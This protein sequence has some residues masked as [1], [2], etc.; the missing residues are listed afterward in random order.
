VIVWA[1]VAL[2]PVTSPLMSVDTDRASTLDHV[3]ALLREPGGPHRVAWLD[4]LGSRAGRGVVTRAE[5]LDHRPASGIPPG[6]VRR[7][8]AGRSGATVPARA[9]VPARWPAGVLRP[10]TVRAFNELRYR[11]APRRRRGH[12]EPLGG[13]MFPLD[14]LEAWPRLYGPLGLLQY[15]LVVPGGQERVLEA[16]IERL[17]RERVPCYLAVLKD[18]GPA[19]DAPLSFPIGGWTLALDLPRAAPGVDRVLSQLDELVAAAGGRVYLTKDAR[20][21]PD[22]VRAMYPRLEEWRA[23]RDRADPDRLWRSD[24][25]LRTGLVN[26]E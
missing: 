18:F 20:L 7:G 21:R 17:A 26:V 25:A 12:V 16:V 3:L 9:Q 5:H 14:V 10:S 19:N 22:A 23:V 15:Q 4:L 2:R 24:L 6:A 8:G 1:R 13:H 11:R